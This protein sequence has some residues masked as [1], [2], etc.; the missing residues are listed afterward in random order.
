MK[1]VISIDGTTQRLDK[2]G[3]EVLFLRKIGKK[4]N[5]DLYIIETKKS[6]L[7]T[8]LTLFEIDNQYS[9]GSFYISILNKRFF[10]KDL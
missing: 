9:S 3:N 4:F 10:L 5:L 8:S 6:N 7:P 2:V 1:I